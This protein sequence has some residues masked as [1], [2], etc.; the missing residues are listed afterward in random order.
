MLEDMRERLAAF[1]IHPVVIGFLMFTAVTA[2]LAALYEV[3]TAAFFSLGFLLGGIAVILG[4]LAERA[5]REGEL[6]EA[7][8]PQ[9]EAQEAPEEIEQIEYSRPEVAFH[10]NDSLHD[11]IPS[12]FDGVARDET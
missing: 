5:L 7:P 2:G 6:S 1:K 3:W 12:I 10:E 9:E 4:V 8:E 11:G